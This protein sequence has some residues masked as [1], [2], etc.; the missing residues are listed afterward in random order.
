VFNKI[1]LSILF[2]F[3]GLGVS[4]CNK[5]EEI[6]LSAE[7]VKNLSDADAFLNAN[8]TQNGVVTTK[9]GLQYQ[10]MSS[11]DKSSPAPQYSSIV[12]VNYEG[13]LT[14][15]TIFDSSYQSGVAAEF[16]VAELIP[17]WTE[18]LQLMHP[19]DEWVIWVHPRIGYGPVGI[20]MGCGKDY[21]CQIPPNAL[22]IFK[23]RLE[24]IVGAGNNANNAPEEVLSQ[25][26]VANLVTDEHKTH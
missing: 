9:S 20:P 24:S 5:K 23:M 4:S 19:G 16:P 21:P 3:M 2:V 22:L 14:D 1:L 15:G 6:K 11:G 13:K 8:K 26:E 17:A 12:R 10:I 25:N 7:A 18:A